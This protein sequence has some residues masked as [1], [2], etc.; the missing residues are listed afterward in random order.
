MA[1]GFTSFDWASGPSFIEEQPEFTEAASAAMAS[2]STAAGGFLESIGG[3]AEDDTG[4]STYEFV[5]GGE[6]DAW[7]AMP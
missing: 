2:L 7:G 6:E 1:K 4:S 3:L 5:G